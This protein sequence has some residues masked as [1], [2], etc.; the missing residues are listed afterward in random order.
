M[1]LVYTIVFDIRKTNKYKQ[2][3]YT[4]ENTFSVSVHSKS[5]FR[6]QITA[7]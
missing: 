5:K 2:K 6:Q 1:K 7:V 3:Q 4:A